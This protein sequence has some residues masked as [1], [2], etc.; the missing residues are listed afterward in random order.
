MPAQNASPAPVI[1]TTRAL[2]SYRSASRTSVMSACSC[3]FMAFF[4][5]GLLR[6]TF[7]TR[8]AMM[9]SIVAVFMRYLPRKGDLRPAAVCGV[10]FPLKQRRLRPTLAAEVQLEAPH[11]G[12]KADRCTDPLDYRNAEFLHEPI[13]FDMYRA[14][15]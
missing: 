13:R 5:F 8:S 14:L 11:R 7:A 3:G 10:L 12:G 15:S 6:T 2:S 9:T 1:T 4:F